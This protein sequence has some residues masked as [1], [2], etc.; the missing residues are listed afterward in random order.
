M[1]KLGDEIY[2]EAIGKTKRTKYVWVI[3]KI[4]NNERWSLKQRMQGLTR[5]CQSCSLKNA[6][7]FRIDPAKAMK[8]GRI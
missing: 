8:E 2:G 1:P 4:C 6:K 5:L 3:C 7:T